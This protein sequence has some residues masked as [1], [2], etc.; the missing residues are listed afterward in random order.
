M[1]IDIVSDVIC[2]WCFI[3]KRRLERA[4]TARAEDDVSLSWRAFQLNPDMPPEGMPREAYLAAKFGGAPQASRIYAAVRQAGA[5]ENIP[6][7]FDLIRRTPNS[8]DAHRLIRFATRQGRAEALVEALFAAYFLEGR[9][10]GD[11]ATLAA[12]AEESGFD[13]AAALHFLDSD[14]AAAE[15]RDEDRSARRLGI[16]A[17]PCFIIDNSYAISG[18]QDPEFFLPIFDL[19][20]NAAPAPRD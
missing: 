13:R 16:N 11:R 15:I 10:I 12:V 20:Q 4:L 5:G 9:D 8:L 1:H 17:V 14:A 19:A 2:P 18:A 3:G 6:F 7:A